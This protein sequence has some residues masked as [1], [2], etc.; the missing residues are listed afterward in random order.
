[1]TKEWTNMWQHMK[2]LNGLKR[3]TEKWAFLRSEGWHSRCMVSYPQRQ[4]FLESWKRNNGLCSLLVWAS[5][6][7]LT[8]GTSISSSAEW[9][10]H[11][12]TILIKWVNSHR[13]FSSEQQILGK[14]YLRAPLG[15]S[16]EIISLPCKHLLAEVF[17][18][19]QT[20]Q[21]NCATCFIGWGL[22]SK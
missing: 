14:C 9:E 13:R 8:L 5:A 7:Y 19:W 18:K 4:M 6:S 15:A 3:L 12:V 2:Y 1:M 11:Q 16:N 22:T 10:W 21:S 20:A 17:T